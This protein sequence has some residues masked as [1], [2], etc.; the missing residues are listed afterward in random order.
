[1]LTNLSDTSSLLRVWMREIRD[2]AIQ[3]D[4]ARFRRNMERIG[5]VAAYELSK[6][7]AFE[8]VTVQTPM[9]ECICETLQQQPVIATILRAGL[10]LQQ[11]L[12]NYFD[13]ADAAFVAAYRRHNRDGSFEIE[14][15]Y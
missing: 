11:G 9:G 5:E 14:Q 7:L 10:P 3:E 8:D 4:R 15:Q 6:T 12:I 13:R 1:M 2:C